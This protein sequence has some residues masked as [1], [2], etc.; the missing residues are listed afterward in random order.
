MGP[1]LPVSSRVADRGHGW[2]EWRRVDTGRPVGGQCND[3]FHLGTGARGDPPSCPRLRGRT[4]PPGDRTLRSS[5]GD[6]CRRPPGVRGRTDPFAQTCS[7]RRFVASAHAQG[8]GRNGARS[9]GSGDG[10]GRSG[11]NSSRTVGAQLPGSRRRKHAH[12]RALGDRRAEAEVPEASVRRRELVV[13]R[14]DRAGGRRFRSDSH[15]HPRHQ[16]RRRVDHQ[17]SQVVH[18]GGQPRQVR[19]SHRPYRDG[20]SRGFTRREHRLHHRLASR[21]LEQRS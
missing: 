16:G 21:G 17:R 15:S 20:R 5:G 13:L 4:H 11:T 18:L 2:S 9:R 19:H 8:V 12:A 7:E 10:S 1:C 14:D 3:R 6:G